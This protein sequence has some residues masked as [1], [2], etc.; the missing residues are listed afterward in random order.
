MRNALL[1]LILLSTGVGLSAQQN[2]INTT[3]LPVLPIATGCP[4]NF[5]AQLNSQ[6]RHHFIQEQQKFDDSQLLRLTFSHHNTAKILGA[7]ITV[8]GVSGSN[9]AQYLLVSRQTSQNKTQT[10]KLDRASE[11][12]GLT[13]VEVLV[14]KMMFVRWAEVTELRFADGSIWHPS[15]LAQCR[16]M[17]SGFQLLSQSAQ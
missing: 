12:T 2:P 17:P 6:P 3:A 5:E 4:V 11:S 9:S 13:H 7:S 16:A 10:F 14:T 8:H 15:A 1:L